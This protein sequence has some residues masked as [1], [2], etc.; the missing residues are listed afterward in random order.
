MSVALVGAAGAGTVCVGDSMATIIAPSAGARCAGSFPPG[1][2]VGIFRRGFHGRSARTGHEEGRGDHQ[3][4]Q[5]ERQ[6]RG[7]RHD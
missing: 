2:V 3:P 5:A 4:G 6:Q 1:R 7:R